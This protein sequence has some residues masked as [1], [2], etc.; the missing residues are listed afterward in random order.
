MRRRPLS[1]PEII[2]WATLYREHTGRHPTKDSG[3]IAHAMGETWAGIDNALRLGLRGL[4]A[5]G[6]LARLL[7]EHCGARNIHDLPV[8]TED[9]I[10]DWADAWHQRTGEW[11][12]ADAGTIP[13]TGGEKWSAVDMALRGGARGL[14]G[15][16]SLAQLL[17][18]RR[19][20]R[21]RK[22]LPPL[23]EEQ[24]LAWVDAYRLRHG[25]WPT[26]KSGA[27]L[28]APGETWLAVDMAL[29]KALRGLPGGS[30]LALLLAE[31]RDVR[32]AWTRPLLS[33]AL[34]L[35]WADNWH[36]RTGKWPNLES[37]AIPDTQ[38]ETWRTVDRALRRGS[39]GLRQKTSLAKLLAAERG[40]RNQVSVPRLS[41]KRILVWARAHFRRH[42]MW[43]TRDAGP[44]EES[45]DDTWAA[46][47]AALREGHRGLRPG[48]SLARLL[49]SQGDKRNLQDLPRLSKRKILAWA[50]AH[51][52]RTGF[53]PNVNSGE[54]VDAANERWDLID[55]ALR[56]GHRGLS[57]G[58]SLLLLLVKKRGVRHPL[59]LPPLT[60]ELILSWV[61]LHQQCHGQWPKYDNGPIVDAPGETW[62]AIDSALRYGK[63]GLAGGGSLAKLLAAKRGVREKQRA[64][65]HAD[66]TIGTRNGQTTGKSVSERRVDR[67]GRAPM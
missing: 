66:R 54:V 8:L 17:Q 27:I 42:G 49:A 62:A 13:D 46:I 55:N 23:T 35:A 30:S 43:P 67:P 44:I 21:N 4:P 37:G 26:A 45:P 64:R 9:R 58:S 32:N 20:V 19:G 40:V 65:M 22:G 34:I 57:G 39:R 38:G 25:V 5:G 60:E 7:A 51:F 29:R 56:Q 48:S 47:D 33:V 1:I 2:Q 15:G 10:L 52:R 24:I 28:D 14:P 6:S 11:P 12:T 53:W 3:G 16:S 61:D 18:A 36:E 31:R 63:R 59:A 41:R 50:D